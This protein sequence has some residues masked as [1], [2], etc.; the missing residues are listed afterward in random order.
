MSRVAVQQVV[1]A[2]REEL[3]HYTE[4]PVQMAIQDTIGRVADRL[5]PH[6]LTDRSS[7][8]PDPS[9]EPAVSSDDLVPPPVDNEHVWTVVLE[10]GPAFKSNCV[11]AL[12]S[13]IM[14]RD[15]GPTK[16]CL[17]RLLGAVHEAESG[18]V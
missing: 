4:E 14:G 10:G 11:A 15:E 5:A 13:A 16:D 8:A 7:G 1:D 9:P 18:R 6:G 2:L 17:R 12:R 3:K